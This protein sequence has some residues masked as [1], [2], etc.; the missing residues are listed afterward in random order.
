MGH[1]WSIRIEEK[2]QAVGFRRWK[3]SS[4]SRPRALRSEMMDTE[5]QIEDV[6]DKE[7]ARDQDL[8]LYSGA[9]Q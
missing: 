2:I 8:F 7:G 5:Q 4:H 1:Y 3:I 9:E 6:Q